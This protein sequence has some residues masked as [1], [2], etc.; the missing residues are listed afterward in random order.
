M[1]PTRAVKKECYCVKRAVMPPLVRH[2][3]QAGKN[4]P[5]GRDYMAGLPSL[6]LQQACAALRAG[7]TIIYPT[8]TFY[9]IG[10]NALDADAVGAVFG[11]KKRELSLPLPVSVADQEQLSRIV[12]YVPETAQRLMDLFWPGPLS[13]VF[14]AVPE[15]PDLLTANKGQLAVRCSPHPAAVQLCRETGMVLVASSANVSGEA[16]VADVRALAPEM[17]AGVTGVYDELPAPQGGAP[18]TVVDIVPRGGEEVVRIRRA[19][20][21]SEDTLTKAGFLVE[22]V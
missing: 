12:A 14:P 1:V 9:G 8:E 20:A 6:T 3:A 13:I 4:Y 5:G 17:L 11:L 15:V 7:K 18:S 2:S 19:G 21:I 22:S 10:C 16:P